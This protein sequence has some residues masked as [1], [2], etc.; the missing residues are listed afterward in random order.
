MLL[1]WLCQKDLLSFLAYVKLLLFRAVVNL[2]KVR[3]GVLT[4]GVGETAKYQNYS[5][6][7]SMTLFISSFIDGSGSSIALSAWVLSRSWHHR[8]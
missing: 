5:K 8:T 3:C 7:R 1:N 2:L 6:V 4:V